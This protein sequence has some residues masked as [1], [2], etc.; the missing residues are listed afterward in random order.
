MSRSKEVALY[1]Y[2]NGE[3][4]EKT[5]KHFKLKRSS[6]RRELRRFKEKKSP[7]KIL[8]L[9]IETC[10]MVVK[11]WA[12]RQYGGYIPYHRI[13]KDWSII[14]WAAK[15]LYSNKIFGE[16]VTPDEAISRE[17]KRIVKPVWDL[18]EEAD[19]VI[20][21]N[22]ERF[23]IRKLNARFIKTGLPNPPL[24]YLTID[25]LK[26]A[27][28]SFAFSSHK[29]AYITEFLSL[30]EKLE[31]DI[32]L[33]DGCEAGNK[34]DLKYM[35]KYCK[36]DIFGLEE[37]Y[38]KLR[39]YMKSHPNVAIYGDLQEQR[40]PACGSG[41]IKIE[42]TYVTPMSEYDGYRC[43]CGALSRGRKTA[44]TKFEREKLIRSTA[45]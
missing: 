36:Q 3:K 18:L 32:E 42:G 30:P 16:C 1:H 37:M 25:T 20:G 44:L 35:F 4:L 12:L 43:E 34:N 26:H 45:K 38:L 13:V 19:I 17:D 11:V 31:T 7:A 2:A 9:D 23:D 15:W 39:P 6:I 5:A 40:C 14:C 21:H 27:R 28:R 24:P 10:Q 8:L 33:W 22:V 41:N 29:Q